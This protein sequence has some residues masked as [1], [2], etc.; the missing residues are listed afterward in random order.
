MSKLLFCC[1]I[2]LTLTPLASADNINQILTVNLQMSD[3]ARDNY[4]WSD[5]GGYGGPATA[6]ADF[7][8]IGEPWEFNTSTGNA[9]SWQ[10]VGDSYYATFGYGG[11]FDM[12]GPDGLTFTGV[13]TSGTAM[14]VFDSWDVHVAYFGQWSDGLYGDG[15]VDLQIGNGGVEGFA[16]L[17]S[18]IV[19]E[20]SSFVLL[21]SG[22]LGLWAWGRKLMQ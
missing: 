21:V 12:N 20:P 13:V 19:P 22:I 17:N 8:L 14:F 1:L 4:C 9:L 7:S 15:I 2:I 18:Q 11:L 6:S 3:C 16:S 10:F 5:P